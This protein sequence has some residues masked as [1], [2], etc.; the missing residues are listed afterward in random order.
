MRDLTSEGLQSAASCFEGP[1]RSG[2]IWGIAE[3]MSVSSPKCLITL[4]G[5]GL[6]TVSVT[7]GCSS[8]AQGDGAQSAESGGD[9]AKVGKGKDAGEKK[10]EAGSGDEPKQEDS[11]GVE[12]ADP[13]SIIALSSPKERIKRCKELGEKIYA[14]HGIKEGQK[15]V[16]C[17]DESGPGDME[18]L[19]IDEVCKVFELSKE[20]D[21]WTCPMTYDQLAL[22]F[23]GAPQC[24]MGKQQLCGLRIESCSPEFSPKK[25]PSAKALAQDATLASKLGRDKLKSL[26]KKKM[27]A[28]QQGLGLKPGDTHACEDGSKEVPVQAPDEFCEALVDSV[29]LDHKNCDFRVGDLMTC[30]SVKAQC[31]PDILHVCQMVLGSCES[32]PE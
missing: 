22:C 27:V 2:C 21:R 23:E 17:D 24:S 4:F 32:E 30:L 25:K 20:E 6:L 14:K 7:G 10:E 15:V 11:A 3:T 12:G 18:L 5:A 1:G 8:K 19:K 31:E 16:E 28:E 13:S 9:N 29:D 26:C